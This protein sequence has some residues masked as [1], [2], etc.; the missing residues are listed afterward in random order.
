[1]NYKNFY[2]GMEFD[3]YQYF[4]AHL[5]NE[6]CVF[7]VFAPHAL[8]ISVIGDFNGWQE[9]EMEKAADGNFWEVQIPSAGEGMRYK[10]RIYK[11]SQIVRDHCDPYGFYAELRPDTASIIKNIN[12]Y[13]FHDDQWMETR[14]TGFENPVNI[15]ELHFGSWRKKGEKEEDW[16][17]YRELAEFVIPYVRENGYNYIEIMPLSEHPSDA[18]WGY[19]NTGF[20]APTSRYGTPEELQYFVDCCHQNG[21]GVILDFVPVHFAVDDF[22]L[23]NF[24]GT[25]LYEYPHASVGVSEWGSRNFMHTKGEVCSFLQSAANYWLKEYHFDGLRMDAVR[26]LI[27]WQGD[28]NRGENLGAIQFVKNMN[29]GLK[30]R[31][32]NILLIAEDSS[33]YPNV[34]KSVAGG[35]LGFD[36]KWDLG[37]MNDT[38][39]FFGLHPSERQKH[40]HKLTFSMLYYYNDRYLLPLSHDE[41]VHGKKTIIDKMYGEYNDK[42]LQVRAFYLYMMAHPGKK[43]NFMGNEIAQFREWDEKREQDWNILAYPKH[44][45]F[46][47]YMKSLNRFYCSS[48]ALYENDYQRNGF[49]W[50]DCH[51]ERDCIYVFERIC[52]TQRLLF[53]FNFSDSPKKYNMLID[54]NEQWNLVFLSED[55]ENHGRVKE[56]VSKGK[57]KLCFHLPAYSGQCYCEN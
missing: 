6:G 26:N 53:L 7:R 34:T 40:Y 57:K 25:S 30:E 33:S 16:Y 37:W 19:Q 43:L 11:E 23:W 15:Y 5:E 3:A 28:V 18:S 1:M 41:A 55:S 51:Q 9:T 17:T 48:P 12:Q 4:G 35:G 47:D 39:D 27:Y 42:F 46:A 29:R 13:Q 24:D 52:S 20:F 50:V 21:I 44:K 31:H 38:L 22:A 49:Q 2:G 54:K 8:K 14:K 10:Y 56:S 45:E 36:Y 32:D